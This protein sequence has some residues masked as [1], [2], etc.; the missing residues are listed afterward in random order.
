MKSFFA[1]Q[2]DAYA[3]MFSVS[4]GVL[5]FKDAG[6]PW[7]EVLDTAHPAN[8]KYGYI[9][10]VFS[11]GRGVYAEARIAALNI[12]SI[13][14]TGWPSFW[15]GDM[16][17]ETKRGDAMPGWPNEIE[18]I[19]NDYMEYNPNWGNPGNWYST[20]HDWGSDGQNVANTNSV[21]TPAVGTD[22]TKYHTYGMLWVP[23]SAENGWNGYRQAYF[24]G[25]PQQAVCWT[26]SQTYKAGIFPGTAES[27]GSYLFS[28]TDQDK[29]QLILGS[30]QGGIPTMN[31]DY[32]RVYAVDASSMT[33]VK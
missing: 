5:T 25:V 13:G 28:L 11:G 22:Y 26:G 9:G 24:D 16:K 14:K 23:A 6:N 2:Y 7:S 3:G 30:S 21:I 17:G 18:N 32:V 33:V 19:E 31:V 4:N 8:N 12:G 15:S 20:M 10:T 27:M 1:S 29:F